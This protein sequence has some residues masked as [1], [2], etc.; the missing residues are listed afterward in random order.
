MRYLLNKPLHLGIGVKLSLSFAFV[1]L[2]T[3]L[4]FSI[5]ILKYSEA[6]LMD[7]ITDSVKKVVDSKGVELRNALLNGDYWTV[8]KH[9]DALSKL[10]G[11]KDVAV[12]DRDGR[13]VAHSDPVKY[14]IGSY[15][16]KDEQME[17]IPVESYNQPIAFIT[18]HLDHKAIESFL[19]PLKLISI[20]LTLLSLML[21]IAMGSLVSLRISGRLKKVLSMVKSFE[22]GKLEKVE[23]LEKDEI[24]SF[25]LHMY[26]SFVKMDTIIKNT[27]FA[28]EF[29]QNLINSLQDII[30]IIDAEGGIYFANRR[31]LDIGFSYEDLLG[32]SL[33][34]L[35]C[36]GEDRRRIRSKLKS[37]GSF[38][39]KVSIRSPKGTVHTA[40]SFVP[41]EDIF[42]VSVKDITQIK[43]MEEQIKRMELFSM[44]GEL[45]AGLAHELKNALL[46]L[47]LL[48]DVESWSKEDIRVV[49][50]AI[51]KVN[52]IVS[53]M[54]S[55]AKPTGNA[56]DFISTKEVSEKWMQVYEPFVRKKS[57]KLNMQLQD[58]TFIT[59]GYAFRIILDNLIKNALEAVP[60]G[61]I[62][63]V[64]L[65]KSESKVILSVE[66]NGPG[67]PAKY[68]DKVFDPFFTTKKEGT[69]LGLPLVLKYTYKL[70]GLLHVH[71]EEGKGTKFIVEI[72][73][74]G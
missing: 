13:V 12:L 59:D 7:Y 63:R 37:R 73:L 33:L 62:V 40:I 68:R 32:R 54:L 55:F 56:H 3:S 51:D 25:A 53:G 66:D 8:F 61:G 47:R 27:F 19:K 21:G 52:N 23:F 65:E 46:P 1:V 60:Y 43:N 41:V 72:P 71:S 39:E 70:G 28:K 57:I 11:I 58:F 31:I 14:P 16:P 35:I 2:S 9:V 45:S 36:K 24:N 20:G 5:L 26:D 69:G 38:V 6:Y 74:K 18:F 22:M 67:I 30:F 49:R 29:Y 17:D 50:F 64:S 15:L 44:L 34:A 48:S 10:K 42:V 4:P